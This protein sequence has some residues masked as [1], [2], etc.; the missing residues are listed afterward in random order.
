MA[1]VAILSWIDVVKQITGHWFSH[2]EV[3]SAAAACNCVARFIRSEGTSQW[4]C[5]CLDSCH[6]RHMF[7]TLF[8]AGLPAG[9][10]VCS[11]THLH[12]TQTHTKGD[13]WMHANGT[14]SQTGIMHTCIH[15]YKAAR[16]NILFLWPFV[17]SVF[18][19]WEG[20][21]IFLTWT[22]T[23]NLQKYIM[24]SQNINI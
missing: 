5:H 11:L 22:K 4:S 1:G 18:G 8:G 10:N 23:P 9:S 7:S 20:F 3:A 15:S 19:L 12:L 21:S 14:P 2:Y 6:S 13:T 16:K 17:N 24:D